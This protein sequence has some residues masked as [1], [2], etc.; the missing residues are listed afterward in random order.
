MTRVPV[1]KMFWLDV[2]S[3]GPAA[4]LHCNPNSSRLM[5]S[6]CRSEPLSL[7]SVWR[8]WFQCCHLLQHSPAR[9][10]PLNDSTVCLC[11]RPPLLSFW[12][13][14]RSASL[15]QAPNDELLNSRTL[16]CHS[17]TTVFH[18]YTPLVLFSLLSL[19]F[20]FLTCWVYHTHTQQEH[21]GGLKH[22]TC[23][24]RWASHTQII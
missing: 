7:F 16:W 5:W 4:S 6:G 14:R 20:P 15:L 8:L 3:S 24:D 19:F 2:I 23:S 21:R 11:T 22:Y 10:L 17:T 18:L 9:R 1:I 12:L 13:Q